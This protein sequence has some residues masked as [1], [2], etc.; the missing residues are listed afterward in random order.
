MGNFVSQKF[1]HHYTKITRSTS[2]SDKLAFYRY[3]QI[4]M[5]M[6]HMKQS[7]ANANL[8][9]ILGDSPLVE[10]LPIFSLTHQIAKM[11]QNIKRQPVHYLLCLQ[12]LNKRISDLLYDHKFHVQQAQTTQHE[13]INYMGRNI[14]CF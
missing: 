1:S 12:I 7:Q 14:L 9:L 13:E 3:R 11:M 2:S 6:D 10:Q 5:I 4:S 8:R